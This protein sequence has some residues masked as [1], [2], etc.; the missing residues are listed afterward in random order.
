MSM[1]QQ[2]AVR[3]KEEIEHSYA[4]LQCEVR[5]LAG[6]WTVAVTNPRT[7]EHF[8]VVDPT[9]WQDRLM[10]MGGRLRTGQQG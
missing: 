9:T 10:N 5:E 8:N 6:V 4:D 2:E 7:N 3:L 1:S